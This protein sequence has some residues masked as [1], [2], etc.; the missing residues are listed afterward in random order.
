[1]VKEDLSE[2][3]KFDIWVQYMS[4]KY[5]IKEIAEKY[6]ITTDKVRRIAREQEKIHGTGRTI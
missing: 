6:F 5:Y 3:E 2:N 4:G 1:M